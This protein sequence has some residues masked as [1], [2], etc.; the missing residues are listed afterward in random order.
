MAYLKYP[1]DSGPIMKT[2]HRD[3]NF[4]SAVKQARSESP[5]L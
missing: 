1:D 5:H 2:S 3:D 4:G